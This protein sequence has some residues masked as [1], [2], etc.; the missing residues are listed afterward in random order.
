MIFWYSF[1]LVAEQNPRAMVRLE[2]L[3]EFKKK[4]SMISPGLEPATSR[5]V[6]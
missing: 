1:L 6:A 5:L 3:V 2:G 4:N